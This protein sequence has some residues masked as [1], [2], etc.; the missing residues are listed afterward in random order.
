MEHNQIGHASATQADMQRVIGERRAY[1]QSRFGMDLGGEAALQKHERETAGIVQTTLHG[2]AQEVASEAWA[3]RDLLIKLLNRL[4]PVMAPGPM[5]DFMERKNSS[6]VAAV[7]TRVSAHLLESC[8][9]MTQNR[10][11]VN[12]LFARLEV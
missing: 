7:P 5:P 3:M 4:E 11:L 2:A 6:D 8:N 1:H 9:V 12:C 10:E